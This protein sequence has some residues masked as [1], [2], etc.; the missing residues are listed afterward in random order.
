MICDALEV[1]KWSGWTNE[2][3]VSVDDTDVSLDV[4]NATARWRVYVRFESDRQFVM[5]SDV[6]SCDTVCRRFRVVV[7]ECRWKMSDSGSQRSDRHD[8]TQES[9]RISSISLTRA[10]LIVRCIIIHPIFSNFLPISAYI[11]PVGL[12]PLFSL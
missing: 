3:A 2:A 5:P 11:I 7:S 1:A 12:F 8:M 9:K 10:S 4:G 6:S